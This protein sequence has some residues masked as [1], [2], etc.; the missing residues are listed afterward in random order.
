MESLSLI[1]A[2]MPDVVASRQQQT[3]NKQKPQVV[4]TEPPNSN[5]DE[6]M[7]SNRWEEE[8]GVEI[9]AS[10][11]TVL[12]G[13]ESEVFICLRLNPTTFRRVELKFRATKMSPHLTDIT[14]QLA[15]VKEASRL[16]LE[17]LATE[18]REWKSQIDDLQKELLVADPD[19]IDFMKGYLVEAKEKV[20]A[21]QNAF[22]EQ[23]II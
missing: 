23:L 20:L 8:T 18:V 6:P 17:T 22:M 1:D 11:S 13:H 21:M 9:P 5:G 15:S 4:K 16:S 7:H 3:Q 14:V 2:V 10:K 19:L 12:R